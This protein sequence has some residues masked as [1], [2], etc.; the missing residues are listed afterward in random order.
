MKLKVGLESDLCDADVTASHSQGVQRE[1]LDLPAQQMMVKHST[2][3]GKNTA[4]ANAVLENVYSEHTND[5]CHANS[6]PKILCFRRVNI[7]LE[8]R[9]SLNIIFKSSPG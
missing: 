5:Y 3:D 1:S 2:D 8:I 7:L 9:E 4:L 6:F